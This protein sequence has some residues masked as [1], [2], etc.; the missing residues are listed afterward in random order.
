MSDINLTK[1]AEPTT[2]GANTSTLYVDTVDRRLKQKDDLGVVSTMA[3]GFDRN[4]LCNGGFD[5]NQRI[6]AALTNIPG[7]SATA[8]VFTADR[9]GFTVGNTTTPQYQQVDA[10]AAPETGLQARFYARYTHCR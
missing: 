5:I 3:G 7:A 4:A 6:A 1:V 2:P 9:W 10:I 8:R